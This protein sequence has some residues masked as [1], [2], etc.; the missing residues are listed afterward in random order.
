MPISRL[1]EPTGDQLLYERP[2]Q[3]V[4]PFILPPVQG[5]VMNHEGYVP[6][7]AYWQVLWKHRWMIFLVTFK[8][9]LFRRFASTTAV[10]ELSHKVENSRSKY[11]D[12][13]NFTTKCFGLLRPAKLNLVLQ[14]SNRRS[15]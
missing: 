14:L 10:A 11:S 1:P 12:R 4:E 9:N 5:R 8:N 15:T 7:G 13:R 2:A 6:L 3:A